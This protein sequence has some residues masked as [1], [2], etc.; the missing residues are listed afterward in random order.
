MNYSQRYR[1]D[2]R[3][4][5]Y[6]VEFVVRAFLGTYPGLDMPK[7]SYAGRRVLDLGF[8]DGRNMSFLS[9]LRMKVHGVE[10]SESINRCVASR[11][12]KLGVK[13]ILKVGTNA[14]IPFKDKY[15]PFV[16]SCH[17]GYYVEKKHTFDTNLAEIARV[18]EPDGFW[19]AS[20]PMMD[21][22]ILK[23]AKKLTG[24]HFEIQKDPYGLRKGVIFR[25]FGSAAEVKKELRPFFHDIQVG[26]CDDDYWGI[27]QKL[28][29]V[30]CRR[31]KK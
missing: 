3:K 27:R 14:Q 19:V 4:T 11:L 25:A 9:D 5:V 16:L 13:A 28:W 15:F 26:F 31:N 7:G 24:G 2:K 29:I 10:T 8:G 20:L 18:I 22:Y 12:Q 17:S 21:T 23:G 6:P 1:S 30:V